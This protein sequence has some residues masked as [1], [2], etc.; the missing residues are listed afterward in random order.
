M[1][2]TLLHS[3]RHARTHARCHRCTTQTRQCFSCNEKGRVKATCLVH[4][5]VV[6]SSC[7]AC[8][9]Q[10]HRDV[11][12]HPLTFT[13]TRTRETGNEELAQETLPFPAQSHV[14]RKLFQNLSLYRTR[15]QQS[16]YTTTRTQPH[17]TTLPRCRME[18]RH[19]LT[20]THNRKNKKNHCY[21]CHA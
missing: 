11:H 5:L 12:P 2:V 17:T 1:T 10:T 20:Q 19:S 8:N 7:R 21:A 13:F 4:V 6:F 3:T 14:T 16:H 9:A 18:K 15:T